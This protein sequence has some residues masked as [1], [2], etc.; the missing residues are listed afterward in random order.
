MQERMSD[1]KSGYTDLTFREDFRLEIN[2]GGFSAYSWSVCIFVCAFVLLANLK[3]LR[4]S[5][6]LSSKGPGGPVVRGR[7]PSPPPFTPFTAV[8]SQLETV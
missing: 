4:L 3:R 8:L 7:C 2:I 6:V 1:E 5:V